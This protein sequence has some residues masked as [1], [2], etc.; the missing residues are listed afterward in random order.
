MSPER[1]GFPIEH[2]Q[3]VAKQHPRHP[4]RERPIVDCSVIHDASA[5]HRTPG[6]SDRPPLEDVVDDLVVIE[7]PGRVRALLAFANETDHQLFVV[8]DAVCLLG[9]LERRPVDG[10]NGIFRQNHMQRVVA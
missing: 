6:D 8:H 7:L 4:K 9:R 3:G 2:N 1:V 10:T 5:A